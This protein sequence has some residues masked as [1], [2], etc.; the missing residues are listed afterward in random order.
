MKHFLF[1]VSIS[2]F[3]VATQ[4]SCSDISNAFSYGRDFTKS[5]DVQDL[6][7]LILDN[8]TPEMEVIKIEF[9]KADN[10]EALFSFSKGIA[11]ILYVNPKNAKKAI[12]INIDLKEN[13]V[14]TDTAD[15]YYGKEFARRHRGVKNIQKLGCEKIANNI[16]AAIEMMTAEDI[17]CHGIGSYEIKPNATTDKT[18]HRFSLEQRGG[19][20]NRVTVNYNEYKFEA[21]MEG[22]I[23]VK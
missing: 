9:K 5:E 10:D 7:K 21:D 1:A 15:S 6:E 3:F 12:I 2:L 4:T 16:N 20:A 23:T 22:N 18:V 13:K 14:R 8:I 19:Q 11:E 17:S